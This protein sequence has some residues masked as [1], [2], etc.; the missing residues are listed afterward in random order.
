[1]NRWTPAGV[2]STTRR[3]ASASPFHN[4]ANAPHIVSM[5][6]HVCR[7]SH[8][9]GGKNAHLH[10]AASPFMVNVRSGRFGTHANRPGRAPTFSREPMTRKTARTWLIALVLAL[11]ADL[12]LWTGHVLWRGREVRALAPILQRIEALEADIAGDDDWIGRN[13]RLAQG[14]GRHQEYAE[15]LALRGQRA[16]AHARLVEAYNDRILRI[17]RRFYLAP[18][19]PPNPPLRPPGPA[20]P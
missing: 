18:L 20:T 15:R 3:G 12:A 10:G 6:L 13:E 16:R 19:P 9:G 1:M 2:S 4:A 11:A 5:G 8:V 7:A 14:Y 17:Y